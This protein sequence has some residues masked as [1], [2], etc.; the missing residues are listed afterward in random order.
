[1]KATDADRDATG[2]R[3]AEGAAP[4]SGGELVAGALLAEGVDAVFTVPGES[5]LP[6]LDALYT[7]RDR[8][9]TISTR[10]ESGAGFAADGYAKATGEVGVCMAT[11]GVGSTNMS[12]ALHTAQQDSTPMVALIGQVPTSVKYREAFQEIDLGQVFGSIAKW[13]IDIPS[14][15]RIP[16]LLQQAFRRARSERP[17]P[18]VVG[19]PEDL[20]FASAATDDVPTIRPRAPRCDAATVEEACDLLLKADAPVVL[21]G[22]EVLTSGATPRLVELAERLGLPV[23]NGFRRFDAFPN[24]HAHFVGN[25]APGMPRSALAPLEDADLILALGV[26]FTEFTTAR[27]RYPLPDTKLIHVSGSSDM[28]GEWGS[29]V[30]AAVGSTDLF[31]QDLLAHLAEQHPDRSPSDGRMERLKRYRSTWLR[32]SD[33]GP[34]LEG[35]EGTSIAGVMEALNELTPADTAVVMDVGNFSMWVPRYL[36]ARQPGTSFGAIAGA[37]GYALP[38]AVGV[39][40]ADPKRRVVVVAGDGGFAMTMSELA[41]VKQLGLNVLSI[42]LVNGMF[43]TIRMHQE[44]HYPGRPIATDLHNPSFRGIAEAHGIPAESVRGTAEARKALAGL[45]ER[46]GPALLEVDLGGERISAWGDQK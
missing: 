10:H 34:T 35:D 41:T 13:V 32:L 8:I 38:A 5:F 19:L 16:E 12:I 42:V 26:R 7:H 27:H 1:M 29:P 15:E 31:L 11:R 33:P 46:D 2:T 18:V 23:V 40:V 14:T 43:G 44:M 36:L 6:V 24:D 37:M 4:R 17:G 3:A 28:A 39:A 45:L 9:A 21:A 22:R 30:V 25:L 20:L